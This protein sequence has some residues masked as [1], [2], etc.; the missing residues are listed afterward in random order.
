M[1]HWAPVKSV[2]KKE[3]NVNVYS[4][5]TSRNFGLLGLHVFAGARP[6]WVGSQRFPFHRANPAT[7]QE[8]L[9]GALNDASLADS[10]TLR[11]LEMALTSQFPLDIH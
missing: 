7:P 8:L 10:D 5:M 4:K 1:G 2:S 11:Q 3:R 9:G 6:L